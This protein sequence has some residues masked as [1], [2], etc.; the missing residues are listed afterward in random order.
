M[1]TQRI[2]DA[3]VSTITAM[4]HDGI[5][6]PEL[7]TTENHN[8][9]TGYKVIINGTKLAKI[10]GRTFW[11]ERT[12][13]KTFKIYNDISLT[14]FDTE[15]RTDNPLGG[16]SY[17]QMINSY[18]STA[19]TS[20]D[21]NSL[22]IGQSSKF[23][24]TD[25]TKFYVSIVNQKTGA[26]LYVHPD[27]L[28]VIRELDIMK[29]EYVNV[30]IIMSPV[31]SGDKVLI[32]S[33]VPGFDPGETRFRINQT[34]NAVGNRPNDPVIYRENAY[35]RTYVVPGSVAEDGSSFKVKDP[36][37]L[38]TTISAKTPVY[39][40]TVGYYTIVRGV[41]STQ[42]VGV[43][44]VFNGTTL[45]YS[46][47]SVD[48]S[49][50][51]RIDFAS[52]F[53]AEND[54]ILNI[55][56]SITG[57]GA[58]TIT[59]SN[60]PTNG[61]RLIGKGIADNTIVT[62]SNGVYTVTPS[63]II[64][65]T[66]A[67]S[68]D[69]IDVTVATGNQLLVAGGQIQYGK[70]DLDSGLISE[71]TY[72]KNTTYAPT[73]ADY[74]EVQS[75]LVENIVAGY[76]AKTM[77][78]NIVTADIELVGGNTLTFDTTPTVDSLTGLTANQPIT[79]VRA[80]DKLS[81]AESTGLKMSSASVVLSIAN[82]KPFTGL[83]RVTATDVTRGAKPGDTISFK[84]K[85]TE[86]LWKDFNGKTISKFTI[87]ANLTKEYDY[88]TEQYVDVPLGTVLQ[89]AERIEVAG[90]STDWEAMLNIS[91]F[92]ISSETLDTDGKLVVNGTL[93]TDVIEGTKVKIS[94]KIYD[95]PLQLDTT[96]GAKFLNKQTR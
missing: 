4:T 39:K 81:F 67:T 8:L 62:V 64:T 14:T 46:V 74:D 56:G 17:V 77:Y 22:V 33:T 68:Y 6:A 92:A 37:V 94:K 83:I 24:Y 53:K 9:I 78:D 87:I 43:K 26:S 96:V 38:V 50:S 63:Q 60:K 90:S 48:N 75:I 32:T 19:D 31:I 86:F 61:Q 69:N 91:E 47:T 25:V 70:I 30:L 79:S 20:L 65:F 27:N 58:L 88:D 59:S 41:V 10:D 1:K 29:N 12:G 52:G 84:Y 80:G 34:W 23:I 95:L 35:S 82:T 18:R 28:K 16:T 36:S 45:D 49:N 13:G 2:T 85:G 11:V 57:A 40:D 66:D 51:I 21:I 71:L 42:V 76:S 89:I 55:S 3:I 72:S 73:I 5:T 93:P 7:T 15:I 54:P 44:P